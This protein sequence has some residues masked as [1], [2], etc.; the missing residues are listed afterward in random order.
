MGDDQRESKRALRR[1]LQARPAASGR[2]VSDAV[3]RLA[4]ERL[5]RLRHVV[6][7]RAVVAYAALDGEID[8]RPA[9]GYVAAPA[10]FWPCLDGETLQFRSAALHELRPSGCHGLLEPAGGA[11]LTG[12]GAG[13]VFL[14][15]GV[16]FDPAGAR[17]GRGAGMYD[18]ALSAFPSAVRIGVTCEA[19]LRPT[20]PTDRWDVPMHLVVTES[21]LLGRG[22]TRSMCKETHS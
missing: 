12:S 13:V 5:V 15:P 1:S 7:A 6:E 20:L 21:R 14:V 11:R 9:L 16:A 17:L 4:C 22:A 8:L 10:M 18:R 2:A 3:S 19:R